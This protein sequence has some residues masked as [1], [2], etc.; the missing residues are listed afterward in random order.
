ML[1]LT[2]RADYG[3]RLMLEVAARRN[4]SVTTA[5]VA[6]RQQIPYECLRKVVQTLVSRGLLLS[7]RGAGGGVTLAYPPEAISVLDIVAAFESPAL[8]RCTVDPARCDRR[9]VCAAFPV[10]VEAQREV[11]RV[12]AGT[13]LVDLVDKQRRLESRTLRTGA[14]HGRTRGGAERSINRTAGSGPTGGGAFAR[15]AQAF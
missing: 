15:S 9:D 7:E 10:W 11:E 1:Q 2:R 12:L 4:G 6:Q 14:S 13:R 3:L 5:A 8:N